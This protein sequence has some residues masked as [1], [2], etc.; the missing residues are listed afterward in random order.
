MDPFRGEAEHGFRADFEH[1]S[2]LIKPN[3]DSG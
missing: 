2:G 1:H 3:I